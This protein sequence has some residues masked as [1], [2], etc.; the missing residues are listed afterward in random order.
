MNDE[1]MQAMSLEGNHDPLQDHPE[2]PIAVPDSQGEMVEMD[3]AALAAEGMAFAGQ[4]MSKNGPTMAMHSIEDRERGLDQNKMTKAQLKEQ[5]M[6]EEAGY[7]SNLDEAQKVKDMEA[8]VA[9]VDKKLDAIIAAIQHPRLAHAVPSSPAKTPP[10]DETG[11]S[12]AS[13][14]EPQIVIPAA[15][16]TV[17]LPS[18]SPTEQPESNEPENKQQPLRQVTLRDGRKVAVPRPSTPVTL[19]PAADQTDVVDEAMDAVDLSGSEWDDPIAVVPEAPEEPRPDP[20]MLRLSKLVTDVGDFLTTNDTL[21]FFKKHLGNGLNRHL[22]YNGWSQ[23]LR[24][25]FDIRYKAMVTDPQFITT[26]CRKVLDMDLGHALDVKHV[27][28]FLAATAG[29]TAFAL[30][31]I[32]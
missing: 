30:C 28:T 17:T 15:S 4:Y 5:K 9:N 10:S 14:V 20:K 16:G 19:G 27:A 26:M 7:P 2:A 18:Q 32:D 29:F 31:G 8:K 21:R 6:N 23:K 3:P 22:G 24:T 25:E 1:M 13:P 12:P 11:G